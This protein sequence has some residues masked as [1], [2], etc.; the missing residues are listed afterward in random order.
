MTDREN[1]PAVIN[2]QVAVHTGQRGSLVMRGLVAVQMSMLAKADDALYRQARDAY[3]RISSYGNKH[4]VRELW[5]T[6]DAELKVVFEAFQRLANHNYGKAY[7]PL[8]VHCLRNYDDENIQNRAQH[9]AQL[10]LEWCLAN[11][12]NQDVELWSDL[13]DMYG[14]CSGVAIDNEQADHWHR[15]AAELGDVRGQWELGFSMYIG[16]DDVTKRQEAFSWMDKAA[17]Q[18]DAFFQVWLGDFYWCDSQYERELFWTRRAA[19][20]GDDQGQCKLCWLYRDVAEAAFWYRK[21]AEQ[22][23]SSAQWALGELYSAGNGVEQSDEQAVY[24]HHKAAEQSSDYQYDLGEMYRVGNGVKQ[25]DKEA[26]FWYRKAAEHG[27]DPDYRAQWKLGEMYIEGKGVEQSDE[28]VVYWLRKAAEQDEDY[29]YELGSYCSY[30]I[31]VKQSD[32][33]AA[34]WYR[35]AAEQGNRHAQWA[36]GEMYNAGNGVEQ[37]DEEAIYWLCEAAEQSSNYQYYLGEMYS[38]GKGVEQNDEQA[39][40]WYRKAAAQGDDEAQQYLDSRGID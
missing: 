5:S 38:T 19:E 27:D 2:Q 12:A 18:G 14:N 40:Y 16:C 36:L 8:S 1:L 7:Y 6:G 15:K 21:A 35:K 23:N 29:Q 33:E 4:S 13:G 24:W 17:D 34:F 28:Q 26:V 37:N 10:A 30:G 11:S 25:S 39:V 20:Q 32:E 22:G 9:F 31:Y 3:N